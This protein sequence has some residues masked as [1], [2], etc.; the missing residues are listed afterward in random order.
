M[1]GLVLGRVWGPECWG[2]SRGRGLRQALTPWSAGCQREFPVW[3]GTLAL[4]TGQ[5]RWPLGQGRAAPWRPEPDG[6]DRDHRERPHHRLSGHLGWPGPQGEAQRWG[7][8]A[9]GGVL[10]AQ[11][12]PALTVRLPPC[13]QVYFAPDGSSTEYGAVLVE[14]NKRIKRDLVLAADQASLYAMTQDKVGPGP[15]SG[16]RRR[17]RDGPLLGPRPRL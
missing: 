17:G 6:R 16:A 15:C 2:P 5:P 10:S 9:P 4:P 8:V 12:S 11:D 7:R 13:P 14:I 3:L 1:P